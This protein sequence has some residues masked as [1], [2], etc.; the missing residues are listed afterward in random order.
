MMW[1]DNDEYNVKDIGFLWEIKDNSRQSQTFLLRNTP[2]KTNR[3]Y[4]YRLNG[5]CGET[6]NVSTYGKGVWRVL[7]ILQNGRVKIQELEGEELDSFLEGSGF[8]DLIEKRE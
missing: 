6:D 1:I 5:W 4:E 2:P 3:S 7:K 8:P